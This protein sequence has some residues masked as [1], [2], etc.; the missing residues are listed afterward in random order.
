MDR[1]FIKKKKIK[2]SNEIA[3]FKKYQLRKFENVQ[4]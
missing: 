4:I 2:G 3:I 1:F